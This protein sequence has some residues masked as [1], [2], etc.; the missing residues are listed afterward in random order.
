MQIILCIRFLARQG[1]AL[2][3][4]KA[5]TDSN[6]HQLL[7]LRAIDNP[8]ILT[9]L[10]K[11]KNKFMSPDIQNE[12]ISIMSYQILHKVVLRLQSKYFAIMMDEATNVS[13]SEQ[14]VFVL[15]WVDD[16][17]LVHE[18]FIGLY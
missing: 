5:E 2:R 3:G 18:D 7:L 1:L 16:N 14:V 9:T 15:R 17:L 6:L 12:L 13:N 11:K 8:I 10:E 4:D